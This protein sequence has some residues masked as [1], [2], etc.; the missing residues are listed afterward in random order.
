MKRARKIWIALC[1]W[2][3]LLCHPACADDAFWLELYNWMGGGDAGLIEASTQQ[4]RRVLQDH[5]VPESRMEWVEYGTSKGVLTINWAYA[6]EENPIAYAQYVSQ[7]EHVSDSGRANA[8]ESSCTIRALI[9]GQPYA[10]TLYNASHEPLAQWDIEIVREASADMHLVGIIQAG[11][12][13][14][15]WENT[16]FDAIWIDA[17]P[18]ASA[19][20]S[21]PEPIIRYQFAL[22]FAVQPLFGRSLTYDRLLCVTAPGGETFKSYDTVT[23]EACEYRTSWKSGFKWIDP[24]VDGAWLTPGTYTMQMYLNGALVDEMT[25]EMAP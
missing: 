10:L 18:S 5:I 15:D 7:D 8:E 1:M 13:Q 17:T 11:V 19:I 4:A 24:E 21:D 6:G 20:L 16:A 14:T 22:E 25:F 2:A 9:P 23:F 12:T 3:L